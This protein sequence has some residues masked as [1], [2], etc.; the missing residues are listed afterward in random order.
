[1]TIIL[2]KTFDFEAAQSLPSFPQ[3]HKCRGIHGHSFK[4]AISVKGTVDPES[5]IVYDHAKISDAMRPIL[6]ELD[7]SYLND[8]AGLEKPTIELMC[9]WLWQKLEPQL[10][11]LYEIELHE[12]PRAS[13]IYRGD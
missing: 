5:G 12:T 4:V 10:P 7:H 6:K 13:C 11:G 9:H 1:M 8:I 3:G 2:R